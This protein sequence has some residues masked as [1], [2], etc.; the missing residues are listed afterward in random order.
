MKIFNK[1]I[2]KN[3]FPVV[4]SGL[5]AKTESGHFYIK[6]NKKFNIANSAGYSLDEFI[7]ELRKCEVVCS[8]CHRYRTWKRANNQ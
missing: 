2:K 1:N 6:G 5:I 8:N 7:E 4:P 3:Y